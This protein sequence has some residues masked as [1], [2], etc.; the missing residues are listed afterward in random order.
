MKEVVW[1][2]AY[3]LGDCEGKSLSCIGKFESEADAR[4]YAK[5]KDGYGR[6]LDTQRKSVIIFEGIDDAI[7]YKSESAV[8][9]KKLT[10]EEIEYIKRFL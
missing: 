9:A 7:A 1:Y 8:K 6:T 5:G 2:E 4:E 10:K 3:T